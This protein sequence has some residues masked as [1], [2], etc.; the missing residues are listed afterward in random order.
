MEK[1]K[2]ELSL[3][4]CYFNRTKMQFESIEIESD[5]YAEKHFAAFPTHEE[6]DCFAAAE[7]A[8][9][10]GVEIKRLIVKEVFTLNIILV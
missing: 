3:V 6:I 10:K 4:E 9:A 1:H 7:W 5:N 8:A 2:Q